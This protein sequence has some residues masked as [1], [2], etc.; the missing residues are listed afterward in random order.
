MNVLVIVFCGPALDGLLALALGCYDIKC[1]R[2]HFISS[3]FSLN[4]APGTQMAWPPETGVRRASRMLCIWGASSYQPLPAITHSV[5]SDLR[6]WE[7]AVLLLR[8]VALASS[9]AREAPA[10]RAAL[11]SRSASPSSSSMRSAAST[12]SAPIPRKVGFCLW[13]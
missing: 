11:R 4:S 8:D 7:G 5:P 1:F 9:R 12:H 2:H 3:N 6:R 10:L 13:R